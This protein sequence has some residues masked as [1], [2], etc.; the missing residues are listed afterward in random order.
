MERFVQLYHTPAVLEKWI[1]LVQNA[2]IRGLT[3]GNLSWERVF[4]LRN[5]VVSDNKN[6]SRR[7]DEAK[8]VAVFALKSCFVLRLGVMP[9]PWFAKLDG[10]EVEKCHRGRFCTSICANAHMYNN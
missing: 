1:T 7:R 10:Q 4:Y 6:L 8:T 2:N 9:A 5:E 3:E